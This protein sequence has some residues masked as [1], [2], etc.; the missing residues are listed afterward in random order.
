MR[1]SQHFYFAFTLDIESLCAIFTTPEVQQAVIL[2]DDES[3]RR[4]QHFQQKKYQRVIQ[5]S[6]SS[7]VFP[8]LTNLEQRMSRAYSTS[9]Q[10]PV[11]GEPGV[12]VAG[13]PNLV[14]SPNTPVVPA[15]GGNVVNPT[16]NTPNQ[17]QQQPLTPHAAGL[18]GYPPTR[19]HQR[20]AV[21]DR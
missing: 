15:A 8:N 7:H 13:S 5:E 12:A 2:P 3:L 1:Q 21:S 17:Q 16:T 14:D 19:P 9:S 6:F 10:R 4:T 11:P 20:F 18:H